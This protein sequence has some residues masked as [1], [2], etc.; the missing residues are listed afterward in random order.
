V[1]SYSWLSLT[2]DAA[3]TTPRPL[4]LESLD[5]HKS[6]AMKAITSQE[7]TVGQI[8]SDAG[9]TRQCEHGW[10]EIE[11]SCFRHFEEKLS[12]AS[13]D[14]ACRK[15]FPTAHL[16][17]IEESG[18]SVKA[19][20]LAG[21]SSGTLI[22]LHWDRNSKSL[23]WLNGASVKFQER[24]LQEPSSDERCV[25]LIGAEHSWNPGRWSAWACN[26]AAKYLCSYSLQHPQCQDGWHLLDGECIIYI[27]DLEL[28]FED[29]EYFCKDRF[30]LAHL[31]TIK[32]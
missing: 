7:G 31:A 6:T 32:T 15:A 8:A 21:A 19:A 23:S 20:M 29:A 3:H 24:M 10:V 26:Q 5:S 1:C 13:A 17:T 12:F 16:A 4:A 18:Q 14:D 11:G 22:G 25:R 2:Y 28:E 27:S 9:E 30:P